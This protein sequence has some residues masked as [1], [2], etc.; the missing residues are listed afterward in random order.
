[1]YNSIIQATK[2]PARKQ[3]Y[4]DIKKLFKYHFVIYIIYINNQII[5]TITCYSTESYFNNY[6]ILRMTIV[7][8]N[9]LKFYFL[10]STS[11]LLHWLISLWITEQEYC[12]Y[13]N[14]FPICVCGIMTECCFFWCEDS[15]IVNESIQNVKRNYVKDVINLLDTGVL[16]TFYTIIC[17]WFPH[18]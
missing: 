1:M 17:L 12:A 15:L 9:T 2:Q 5:D 11:S 14:M 3:R 7:F 13:S 6:F 4:Y 16:M 10:R 8:V 18:L